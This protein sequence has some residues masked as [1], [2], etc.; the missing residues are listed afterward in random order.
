M[1]RQQSARRLTVISQYFYPEAFRIN[2]LASEWVRRGYEVTVVTGIPNYPQGHF[3]S[4]YGWF[5]R[6]KDVYNGIKI[7]RLPIIPRKKGYL[8][9]SLNYLSFVISGFFWARLTRLQADVVFI[10]EVSPMTQALPGIWFAKRRKK[11]SILYVQDLWPENVQATLNAKDN[12]LTRYL[13]RLTKHIF[14]R[15]DS[16]LTT[17][18]SFVENIV[19]RGIDPAKV[20]YWPQYAE[21]FYQ[22]HPKQDYT[23]CRIMF[24][25]N[26][27]QA[28][29][30]DL[31]VE[32]AKQ[33]PKE[34]DVTFV[35]VGDG[36]T[37]ESLI[38]EI[39]DAKLEDR[40]EFH[41]A[42]PAE[43]IPSLLATADAGYIGFKANTIFEMT[44][45]AKLQSYL[46]C[47]MPILASA[48]G[49][50]EKIVTVNQLG[51][52]SPPGDVHG[53]LKNILAFSQLSKEE[54][55]VYSNNAKI[56]Q[57]T[58]FSKSRLLVQMDLIL[59]GQNYE[60]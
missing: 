52:V 32:V 40:F 48:K 46:A 23:G 55:A 54:K 21:D 18:E 3:F 13:G 42:V 27:G 33:I 20:Q 24:T 44:I 35:L 19:A 1:K 43:E 47:G 31:L 2:D 51:L 10:N 50:V 6:R 28:Q 9:L 12:V 56:Y 29:G 49:E 14:T 36:R 38:R 53:L 59:K 15:V 37:K 34:V 60:L 8:W 57:E 30:L 17:S 39:K 4:G 41:Q 7:I 26:I 11:T 22:V 25:G 5:K 16:I 45:P 58:H